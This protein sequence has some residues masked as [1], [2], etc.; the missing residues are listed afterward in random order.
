M[1]ST[2]STSSAKQ[3]LFRTYY[4]LT[5]P[6]I[7]HSNTLAA[8]AGYIF[9]AGDSF[10]IS[11]LLAL[12]VGVEAIIA[13]ACV[14]NNILDRRIDAAMKRTQNRA[15]V[16]GTVSVRQATAYASILLLIGIGCLYFGTNLAALTVALVGHLA[17][18]LLYTFTKRFTVHG[19]LIGTISGSTPPVIGY[20][21][22][23]GHVDII[24][25]MLFLV[26]VAW[27]M[28][29]F[30]SIAL[31]RKDDYANA[32]I[33]VL[34][35]MRGELATRQQ[36]IAYVFLFIVSCI[37]LG[38][39]AASL[40]TTLVLVLCGAYW[41]YLCLSPATP[42]GDIVAWSRRQFGWSLMVLLV[43][44]GLLSLDQFFH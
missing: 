23:T 40:F 6:G 17:Y 30:Y 39:V 26:M 14:Y 22:A 44:C 25:L 42:A 35:V 13:S 18:S 16:N 4:Q 12:V 7:V 3:S 20:V 27:Q 24:A 29:H 36:I 8:A 31:F 43:F 28:P 21:A 33:P 32:K 5:K 15:L 2:T 11:T 41:L 1:S 38:V 9:G 10:S 34:S 19:T 37:G